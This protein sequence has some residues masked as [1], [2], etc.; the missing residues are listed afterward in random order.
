MPLLIAPVGT[1]LTIA[2]ISGDDK[3]RKHLESLGLTADEK[4]TVL[5]WEKSGVII[6]VKESR[7]AIDKNV[8]MAIF[9]A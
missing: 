7:L 4:I 5:S 6:K 9:V 8:A 3:V 1:E 2:R